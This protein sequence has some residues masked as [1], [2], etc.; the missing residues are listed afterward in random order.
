MYN[1]LKKIAKQLIPRQLLQ[2]NESLFRKL[3]SFKYKGNNHQCNICEF[4]L[5]H[6]VDINGNDFLCPNCGSRSRTRRLYKE[7]I[8]SHKLKGNVLHFSPPK[9]LYSKLKKLN[10]DYYSSDFENEFTAD[11]RFD[12]TDIP[13]EDNFFDVII[14]YHILEHIENDLKAMAELYRV[15]KP[16]GICYIQ[17]PYK[18]GDI[19]ED[20]S[21]TS[22]EMRKKLFGQED[23]VRV[24]SVTGLTK[25]L[26]NTGFKTE[27][28]NF[29]R[30][31]YYGIKNETIILVSK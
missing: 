20:A 1:T 31:K 28:K 13:I 25:R 18:E 3:V 5:S 12:I 30:D 7:L 14:C 16:N 23:H 29:N 15:L 8:G 21:V 24:Y 22:P 2:K 19:F 9:T 4:N 17:T 26:T 10:I 11:Y 27:I 6:F